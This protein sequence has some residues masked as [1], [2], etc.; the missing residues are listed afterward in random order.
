MKK[1]ITAILILALL[2]SLAAC[3][4]TNVENKP[5]PAEKEGLSFEGGGYQVNGRLV[6][7]AGNPLPNALIYTGKYIRAITDKDGYYVIKGLKGDEVITPKFMGYKFDRKN[8][9]VNSTSTENFVGD[10]EYGITMETKLP[11]GLRSYEGYYL[12]NGKQYKNDATGSAYLTKI[13]GRLT[14]TAISNRYD[15]KEATKFVYSDGTVEF[16]VEPKDKFYN[17]SGKI[18]M[19]SVTEQKDMPKLFVYVDG[20]KY[21]DTRSS[22]KTV[23]ND[24]GSIKDEVTYSYDVYGLDPTKKGGYKITIVDENGKIA[25]DAVTVTKATSEANF[26]YRKTKEIA[27]E[28][29]P[30][31]TERIINDAKVHDSSYT[32]DIK[33]LDYTIKVFDENGNLIKKYYGDGGDIDESH[34][35]DDFEVGKLYLTDIV[36]W[37]GCKVEFEGDYVDRVTAG[38][39][40]IKRIEFV[41][42]DYYKVTDSTIRS[43]SKVYTMCASFEYPDDDDDD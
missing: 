27:F 15:F 33:K 23:Y 36:V 28:I 41:Y 19:S 34:E 16:N 35:G 2:M 38:D 20:K 26:V 11:N 12:I 39:G 37:A 21:S 25:S 1:I 5:K 6:D 30:R 8:A 42:D 40:S 24:D 7:K 14:V 3:G 43:K 18:D 4:G 13:H 17:I 29:S 32:F 31:H 10:K 22:S 9:E